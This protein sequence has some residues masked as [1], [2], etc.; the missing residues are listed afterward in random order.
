MH[1]LSSWMIVTVAFTLALAL[2]SIAEEQVQ[3]PAGK[4]QVTPAPAATAEKQ[5]PRQEPTE[6]KTGELPHIKIDLVKKTIDIDAKVVLREGE[7]LELLACTV[8]SKEHESV[9]AIEALP[10]HVHFALLMLG[11]EPGAP[12]RWVKKDKDK[13]EIRQGYGPKV[14]VTLRYEKDGKPVE[15]PA[16]EWIIDQKKKEKLASNIW[17]FTGA[18]FQKFDDKEV[19]A[20]DVNGT[21]ITIVS[22]G[23]DLLARATDM[24]DRT[25]DAT[26]A[27]NTEAIPEL[28]TKVTIR[29][30]P[31]VKKKAEEK[32]DEPQANGEPEKPAA[33]EK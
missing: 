16:N 12:M 4:V 14:A 21:A 30:T 28:G 26:W 6:V 22:F 7:W 17:L 2:A 32:K 31:V 19:Y 9:L 15:V 33:P 8:N 25:D 20:A 1:R 29:L 5:T 3:T 11:L 24:T 13:Y 27:A 10:S 18:E 23:D